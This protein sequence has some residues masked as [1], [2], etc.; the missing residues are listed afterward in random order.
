MKCPACKDMTLE[1]FELEPGLAAARCGG[2]GGQW[3]NGAGY[4]RWVEARGPKPPG[5]ASAGAAEATGSG[6][7]D[8]TPAGQAVNDNRKA[9]L[10]PECGRFLT[11]A[12]VGRGLDFLLDRCGSCGGI[13]FDAGEWEALRARGLHDDAHFVFS[14]AWQADVLRRDREAQHDRLLAQ[15]VGEADWA[16]IKRVRAWLDGHPHRTALYAVLMRDVEPP[17]KV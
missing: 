14:D 4:L 8:G 1:D 12:K 17:P 6:G 13:W 9:K 16:E 11:R 7:G 5:G 2:C 10:C 3:V 15:K